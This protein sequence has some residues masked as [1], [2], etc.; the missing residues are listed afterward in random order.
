M[1]AGRGM[2]EGGEQVEREGAGVEGDGGRGGV[3][4]EAVVRVRVRGT[5]GEGGVGR[6]GDVGV[7]LDVAGRNAVRVDLQV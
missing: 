5:E 1:D 2:V 6:G 7:R 4:D 3:D